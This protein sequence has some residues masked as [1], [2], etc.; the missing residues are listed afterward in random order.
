MSFEIFWM[1][2]KK[3][4]VTVDVLFADYP[5]HYEKRKGV[6]ALWRPKMK[7]LTK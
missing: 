1:N 2:A 6:V 7:V 3:L 4:R 5:V